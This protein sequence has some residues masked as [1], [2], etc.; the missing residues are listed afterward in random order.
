MSGSKHST[1]RDAK[2]AKNM[3][4]NPEIDYKEAV[5]KSDTIYRELESKHYIKKKTL[6]LRKIRKTNKFIKSIP[7]KNFYSYDD[8][9]L[10][11]I[12]KFEENLDDTLFP[13]SQ[14]DIKEILNIIPSSMTF[15]LKQISL[16]HNNFE[17]IEVFPGIWI[18]TIRGTT[19]IGRNK[20]N[21]YGYKIER[22][23]HSFLESLQFYLKVDAIG[24][25]IHE[26]AHHY[27]FTLDYSRKGK[28]KDTKDL[29]DEEYAQFVVRDLYINKIC[30][31]IEEKYVSEYM[32]F[33]KWMEDIGCIPLELKYFDPGLKKH[34]GYYFLHGF[35]WDFYEGKDYIELNFTLAEGLFYAGEIEASKKYIVHIL[36]N[37]P[38]NQKANRIYKE[39]F[40]I[41]TTL[42]KPE[43]E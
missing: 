16:A 3:E 41:N 12:Y 9:P 15:N 21:L 34:L 19:F 33:I 32:A 5:K 22:G 24:T 11:H 14:D 4:D 29:D 2:N 1:W 13:L 6:Q 7:N 39:Y 18:S 30:K 23:K 20:I 42:S 8:M 38:N 26:I 10:E 43:F 27:D 31:F 25:L 17:K 40:N 36:K 28:Y 35:F 37:Q